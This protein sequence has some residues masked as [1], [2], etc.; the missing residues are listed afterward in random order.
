MRI[1]ARL[2]STLGQASLLHR[3]DVLSQNPRP[4]IPSTVSLT[5]WNSSG[6]GR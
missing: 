5:S 2:Q 1:R 4:I 3:T 6:C